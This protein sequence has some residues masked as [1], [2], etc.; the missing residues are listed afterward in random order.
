MAV[1]RPTLV[2]YIGRET[3]LLARCQSL[4]F[5]L[6]DPKVTESLEMR[7]GF[8]SRPTIYLGFEP[9]TIGSRDEAMAYWLKCWIPN[10]GIL[11]SEP[12]SGSKFYSAFI[13]LRLMKWVPG[14]PGD[15]NEKSEQSPCSG[16]VSLRQLNPIHK[17]GP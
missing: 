9:R 1:P 6:Y 5:I 14:T 17:K 15:L 4:Q 10:K 2:H 11:V 7:L 12:L 13:L 3:V 16:S 8:K